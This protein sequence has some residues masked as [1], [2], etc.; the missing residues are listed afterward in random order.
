MAQSV[1]DMPLA[2]FRDAVALRPT[3]GCGAAAAVTADLGLALVIKGLRISESKS[4]DARRAELIGKVRI[5]LKDLAELAD[6][7]VAAFE[8]YMDRLR[9]PQAT[10]AQ[11][12]RRRDAVA[13]A[14]LTVTEVPLETAQA[15]LGGLTLALEAL[16]LTTAN[17][18]SDVLAGGQLLHAGLSAVLVSVDSNLAG[19]RD[20]AER[21]PMAR[22]RDDL[23]R[24]A[25][26]KMRWLARQGG[27]AMVGPA[28]G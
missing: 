11:A 19:L 12:S 6:K 3:P 13:E 26:Q 18:R 7:D 22:L 14:A 5:L 17:L 20:E 27:A 10:G 28:S 4:P 25:D 23:Q 24:D 21:A 16:E 1:W 9:L 8:A 15:C 2:A